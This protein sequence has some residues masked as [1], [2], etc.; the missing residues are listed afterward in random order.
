MYFHEIFM[1]YALEQKSL[2]ISHVVSNFLGTQ[3]EIWD[4]FG[5]VGSKPN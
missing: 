3:I 1:K 4:G 2:Y 5:L